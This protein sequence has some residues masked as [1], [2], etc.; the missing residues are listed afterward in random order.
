MVNLYK[1]RDGNMKK[2][3]M[4]VLA[5]ALLCSCE[6]SF[7]TV[8]SLSDFQVTTEKKVYKVGERV[9]FNLAS[10]ADF[11][12]FFSGEEGSDY[13]YKEKDR[14]YPDEML[15]SF[16]TATYPDNGTNP[17]SGRFL[18]SND[19]PGV[20]EEEWIRMSTWH[21]ITDRIVYPKLSPTN[22]ILYDTDN[23]EIADLFEDRPD[24]PIYFCWAFETKANSIRNRFRI[25]N[26]SI[27]GRNTGMEFYSFAQSDF[28][29][30]EG[31]GFDV[32]SSSTYYPRVTD[33]YIVWDGASN[34]TVYKD[35]WAISGPIYMTENL[36]AGKDSG[37][38]IKTIG[39]PIKKVHNHYYTKPGTYVVAFEAKNVNAKNSAVAVARTTITIEGEVAPEKVPEPIETSVDAIE[40]TGSQTSLTFNLRCSA[41]WS[42][43]SSDASIQVQPSQGN[44]GDIYRISVSINGG[45]SSNSSL[46]IVA[47]D[48]RKSIPVSLK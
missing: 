26:W 42:I 34:S 40:M 47:G 16:S 38:T 44:A 10:D 22:Y 8:N 37:V 7:Y 31:V 35:G 48:K 24:A 21:D 15:L 41:N 14:L 4:I 45:I 25:D 13:E 39:D 18:W 11:I 46:T 5:A 1:I 2:F 32:Q 17:E 33:K 9:E 20:Y 6:D 29:M 43:L 27:H 36:N 19:F 3:L 12:V 23:M 30:I 28:H